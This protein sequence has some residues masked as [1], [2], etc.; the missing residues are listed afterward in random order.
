VVALLARD[1]EIEVPFSRHLV[2]LVV[3]G[4]VL[5]VDAVTLL[6]LEHGDVLEL[7]VA[8]LVILLHA[9]MDAAAATDAATDV[10]RVREHHTFDR[11]LGAYANVDAVLRL[12]VALE[13][14]DVSLELGR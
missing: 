6:H 11:G 1:R 10:E 5:E 12:V 2:G 7:G 8:G 9:G 14:G 4:R 3:R 13:P